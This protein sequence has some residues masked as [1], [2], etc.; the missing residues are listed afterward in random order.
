MEQVGDRA[1]LHAQPL[2]RVIDRWPDDGDRI[3]SIDDR[4]GTGTPELRA[5]VYFDPANVVRITRTVIA[6]LA[7][8]EVSLEYI[9]RRAGY[10]LATL[11][12]YF[13]SKH[14]LGV[15][16]LERMSRENLDALPH[17]E[18]PLQRL[19]QQ[20]RCVADLLHRVPALS[21]SAMMNYTGMAQDPAPGV[22][23]WS[24]APYIAETVAK[25][26]AA[27]QLDDELDPLEITIMITCAQ[28]CRAT[29]HNTSDTYGPGDPAEFILRGLGAAPDPEGIGHGG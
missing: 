19:R 15:A 2:E 10:S 23:T 11:T 8:P 25:A 17:V 16:V 14:G 9:A 28:V 6:D 22:V 29:A 24:V 18:D 1:Q 12:S 27:G 21:Y 13:G 20:L 5:D 3:R 7:W 4:F 26:Q